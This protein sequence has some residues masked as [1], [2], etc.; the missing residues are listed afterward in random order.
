MSLRGFHIVFITIC[1]L[2]SAFLIL[3]AFVFAP[4]PST[5]A[6]FLGVTGIVGILLMPL[7]GIYFYRKATKLNL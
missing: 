1:T 2:L 3:W 5:L 4:E 7:Y 6:S